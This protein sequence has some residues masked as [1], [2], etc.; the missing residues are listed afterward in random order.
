M[1]IKNKKMIWIKRFLK[2]ALLVLI[3]IQFFPVEKNEGG[4]E[5]LEP[6]IAETR[7][8]QQV[9]GILKTSCYDCH[10]NQTQYPWYANLAP[11]SFFLADHVEEGKEHLN[12]ADWG[13]YTA[14]RK[15][16]KLEEVL[17]EIEKNEMPL[18]SYTLIHQDAKLSAAQA[19]AIINWV[20]A[21]RLSYSSI[22]QPQ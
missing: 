12:F 9:A 16:H 10:S 5:S 14:K 4:Y 13:N 15:D 3:V 11:V 8:S 19:E 6:F 21:A 22:P 20:K 17:E 7:P 18:D 1:G 2:L